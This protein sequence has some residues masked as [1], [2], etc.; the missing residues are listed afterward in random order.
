MIYSFYLQT[1]AIIFFI[2]FKDIMSKI[3]KRYNTSTGLY[4]DYDIIVHQFIEAEEY[5]SPL[6]KVSSD[7]IP[8][9]TEG[10]FAP[11]STE[12]RFA[13]GHFVP[14]P[15]IATD[16]NG[17]ATL[18]NSSYQASKETGVNNGTINRCCKTGKGYGTSKTNGKKYRFVFK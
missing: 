18:F 16:S 2:S 9:S 5:N 1:S 12:G 13:P 8:D 3:V 10:C 15:I 14:T 6:D 7:Y 17:N 11:D 4:Q